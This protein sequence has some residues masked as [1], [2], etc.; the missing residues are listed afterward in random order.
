MRHLM[1]DNHGCVR[2]FL[3]PQNRYLATQKATQCLKC[4]W[5]Y[6]VEFHNKLQRTALNW[7]CVYTKKVNVLLIMMFPRKICLPRENITTTIVS[8]P[9]L[10]AS[11]VR[12]LESLLAHSL[13]CW[14]VK[15]S[16]YRFYGIPSSK[17]FAPF[18]LIGVAALC[19]EQWKGEKQKR[20][21]GMA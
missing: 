5:L 18:M 13:R 19:D 10:Q 7:T 11:G 21:E 4:V 9:E 15:T 3:P 16:V 1:S 14:R 2:S 6:L 8:S 12:H 20:L 17:E